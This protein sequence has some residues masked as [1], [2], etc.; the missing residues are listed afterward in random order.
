MAGPGLIE[1]VEF[2]IG[3]PRR[4]PKVALAF[5]GSDDRC[6]GITD[7]IFRQIYLASRAESERVEALR[8]RISA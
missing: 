8:M 3:A 5:D 7:P 4:G 1:S 2:R 6:D